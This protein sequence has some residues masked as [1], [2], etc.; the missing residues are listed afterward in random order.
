MIASLNCM[1]NRYGGIFGAVVFILGTIGSLRLVLGTS[2][3]KHA[4][5]GFTERGPYTVSSLLYVLF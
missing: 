1:Q 2:R 3:S 4:P 5:R